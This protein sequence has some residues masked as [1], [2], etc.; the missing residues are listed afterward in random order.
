M[1][2]ISNSRHLHFG[3][4]RPSVIPWSRDC[5]CLM[6]KRRYFN[7]LVIVEGRRFSAEDKAV[8][9]AEAR[10]YKQGQIYMTPNRARHRSAV[11]AHKLDIM[12]P[13]EGEFKVRLE[14]AEKTEEEWIKQQTNSH[15]AL[16]YTRLLRE[17]T[18]AL[19]SLCDYLAQGAND[20]WIEYTYQFSHAFILG[21]R[22]SSAYKTKRN[23][24]SNYI[25]IDTDD[26][27]AA[28]KYMDMTL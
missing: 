28:P 27:M 19:L 24:L 8:L 4:F 6:T 2:S 22:Y 7:A 11:L 23:A 5:I 13:V 16:V 21:G 18:Q 3:L 10:A 14:R 1:R 12:I 26:C 9:R 15:N 25:Y 17:R 20:I